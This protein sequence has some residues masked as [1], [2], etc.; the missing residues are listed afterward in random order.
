MRQSGQT[1][2][3]VVAAEQGVDPAALID[4]LRARG[5][6]RFD[7][8]RF[9]F[10]E[11]LIRRAAAQGDAVKRRLEGRLARLLIDYSQRFEQ[12]RD[13]AGE[14]LART[15]ERF[16]AAADDL[17]RHYEAGDFSGL[18]Q[19]VASL[20]AAGRSSPLAELLTHLGQHTT[21]SS[22]GGAANGSRAALESPGELKSLSYFRSTWSQLS[23][24][25][26]LAQALAQ[27]PENAGPLNSHLLALQSLKQ[28]R[29]IAPD[30]L[31]RFMSYVDTL[32]WLD[33]A[34]S[35]RIAGQKNSADGDR[36][37]KT[38]RRSAG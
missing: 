29:D 28:M 36:K 9:R 10:I 35:S 12:A 4:A 13:Q 16:P 30:Y 24:D 8:V 38:G 34:E 15:V 23:V 25:Q 32:F 19:G 17:R 2:T 14:M 1:V 18:Q 6:D 7:P 22:S 21:G 5:A 37:R 26:Q 20:E 27:V 31:K 11:A 3:P 33:Q